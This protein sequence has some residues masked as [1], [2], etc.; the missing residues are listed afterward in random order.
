[1]L[2]GTALVNTLDMVWDK[3]EMLATAQAQL[4]TSAIFRLTMQ[5]QNESAAIPGRLRLLSKKEAKV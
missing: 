4:Q 5:H 3:K 1:M 2:L